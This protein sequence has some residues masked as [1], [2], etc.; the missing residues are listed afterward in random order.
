MDVRRHVRQHELDGL[1]L[2]NGTP[3]GL[4]LLGVAHRFFEGRLSDADA[5][6][7]DD[8][9]AGVQDIHGV[10][11]P[12]AFLS[13]QIF[14]GNGRVLEH[15]FVR[16]GRPHPHLAV[17]RGDGQPRGPLGNDEGADSPIPLGAVLRG[18]H[19]HGLGN[20]G[21]GDEVLGAVEEVGAVPHGRRGLEGRRVRPAAGLRQGPRRHALPRRQRGQEP[22]LLLLVAEAGDGRSPQRQVGDEGHA[23]RR[24]SPGRLLRH[25]GHLPVSAAAA[26][27]GRIDADA[28]KAQLG[29]S[30]PV[31]PGELLVLVQLAG[32]GFQLPVGEVPHQVLQHPFFFIQ[33]LCGHQV[34][35][36]SNF[37]GRGVKPGRLEPHR[38]PLLSEH[39]PEH[40][41][42]L[43][44]SAVAFHALEDRR[45]GVVLAAGHRFQPGQGR[46]YPGSVPLAA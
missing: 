37:S 1:V 15:H 21:V 24:I 38:F 40:F 3:E 35:P 31:V 18:E 43:P 13:Q 28:G 6:G 42:D 45:N 2:G 34:T 16:A 22:L 12:P 29:H 20:L 7:G 32:P 25:D 39:S 46:G 11:E 9:P 10:A 27:V 8:D 17:L 23:G 26:S 5:L 4:P 33:D 30:L 14:G 41:A 36:I 44:Q 19:H